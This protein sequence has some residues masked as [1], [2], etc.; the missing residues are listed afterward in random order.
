MNINRAP[1][2]GARDLIL[3]AAIM[4]AAGGVEAAPVFTSVSSVCNVGAG[5]S[6]NGTFA[7]T[8]I[9]VAN[10]HSG[11][12]AQGFAGPGGIGGSATGTND[13]TNMTGSDARHLG[14]VSFDAIFRNQN[15]T[16]GFTDVA[17]N[18]WLS[19]QFA[20]PEV[21]FGG[22]AFLSVQG[23]LYNITFGSSKN[24][25]N[26]A[27]GFGLTHVALGV[28]NMP[29][30]TTMVTVPLNTPVG[31]LYQLEVV[32]GMQGGT[33]SFETVFLN[34]LNTLSFAKAGPVF[35]LAQGITVDDIPEL[36]LFNNQF[37]PPAA[38]GAVVPEPP[39]C[40]LV[41]AT[42]GLLVFR[43]RKPASHS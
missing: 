40:G 34:A 15:G 25:V 14:R 38:G 28:S 10:C 9:S 8:Q 37:Q 17:L 1:F 21:G 24:S 19:N 5:P 13:V 16:P 26:P 22:F 11:G 29:L 39:A 3:A 23:N 18:L 31:I 2:W 43:R 7:S 42:L 27:Q 12:A 35:T 6:T 32:A 20:D 4:V 41:A 36:Y 33:A 30:T